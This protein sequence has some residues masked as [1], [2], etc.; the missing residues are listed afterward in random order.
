MKLQEYRKKENKTQNEVAED[1]GV[2]QSNVASWENGLR[3]PRP[4]IMQKIIAYTNGEVQPNDFY[5]VA[6][7]SN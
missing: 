6:N 5:G 7:E 4:E 1:L 2:A 3:I